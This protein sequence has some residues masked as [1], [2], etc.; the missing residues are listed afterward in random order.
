MSLPEKCQR[1]S[2]YV[3]GQYRHNGLP[4]FEAVVMEAKSTG[5]AGVTVFKGLMSFGHLRALEG[6]RLQGDKFS[7]ELPVMIQIIDAP[8]KIAGFV[9]KMKE[10]L[11]VH[12]ISTLEDVSI[13][14]Q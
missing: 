12:G 11:G 9:P 7:D 13:V 3:G 4:L 8:E 10:I 1:L 14:H 2:I 5:L 6:E